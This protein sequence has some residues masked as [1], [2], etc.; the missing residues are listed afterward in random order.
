MPI[1]PV[2]P[3]R[4]TVRGSLTGP[5][6]LSRRGPLPLAHRAGTAYLR[7]SLAVDDGDVQVVALGFDVEQHREDGAICFRVA[8]V[9]LAHTI[10]DL[11]LIHI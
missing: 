6:S 4:V 9:Q 3:S 8:L 5:L 1:D 10:P 7:L 2:D 11:S